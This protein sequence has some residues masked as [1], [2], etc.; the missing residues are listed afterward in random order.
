MQ[1]IVVSDKKLMQRV[2]IRVK[3][4]SADFPRGLENY[5][6]SPSIVVISLVGLV[7]SLI[8]RSLIRRLER[9]TIGTTN[10]LG[11]VG[12]QI[13]NFYAALAPSNEETHL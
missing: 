8:A 3:F 5:Y 13:R 11:S 9:I 4:H 1:T 6:F 12:S 2:G 10:L 7:Y